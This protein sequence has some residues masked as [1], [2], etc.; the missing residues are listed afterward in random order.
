MRGVFEVA[1][2]ADVG[3]VDVEFS[4]RYELLEEL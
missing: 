4:D 3:G 2:V 1:G